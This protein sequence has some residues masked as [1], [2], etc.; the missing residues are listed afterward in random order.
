MN[1]TLEGHNG[2]VICATWNPVYKK[3]TTSDE[4]GLIIVWMLHKGLWWEEMINNRNKSVVK[5]MKWTVDGK[6]ICIIYEDGAVIVGSVDGNRL[7]GKELN[8]EL[9]F[10]EWSPDSKYILFVTSEVEVWVYDADGSKLRLLSLT[11][12]EP[13]LS[14]N[15]YSIAAIHWYSPP[16]STRTGTQNVSSTLL[17]SEIS[18]SL[19]VAFDNGLILLSRGEFDNE[20]IVLDTEL[21]ILS[22]KWNSQGNIFAVTGIL[23]PSRNDSHKVIN[24]I[25]F[26]DSFGKFLR[27]IRIPGENI[28]A[29]TWEGSGL[30]IALAVESFIFFANIRPSYT[31]TYLQNTV[32]YAQLPKFDNNRKDSTVIFWDLTTYEAYTKII[33]NLKFLVSYEDICA[34][35][36]VEKSYSNVDVPNSPPRNTHHNNT[37]INSSYN[38]GY[39]QEVYHVQLRNAIGAVLDSK[40]IPFQP[41][42]CTMGPYLFVATNER[43]VFT[44][45]FSNLTG[46]SSKLNYN[47]ISAVEDNDDNKTS[48]SINIRGMQSRVRLFDIENTSIASAQP[49]ENFRLLTDPINDRITCSAA[50]DKFVLIARKSGSIT[51]YMLPHLNPENSYSLKCEPFRVS[52]NSNSSKLAVIDINGMFSIFDLEAKLVE[53]E[54]SPANVKTLK[55]NSGK[56]NNFEDS[57]EDNDI[58]NNSPSITSPS[59]DSAAITGG[60]GLYYGKK[61]TQIGDRKDVWDMKWAE[62]NPDMICIMEKTKMVV[63]RDDISE[64]PT[65]SSGYIARFKDLEIKA[66]SLDDLTM[67]NINSLSNSSSSN[68]N[69]SSN[70]K[71]ALTPEQ[72]A[73]EC[74]ITFESKLLREMRERVS[75]DGLIQGGLKFADSQI[76]FYPRLWQLL[77]QFALE[78]LDLSTAERA[79]VKIK[80][81]YGIQLVKQLKTMVLNDKMKARAEVA[82]YLN[83]FDEAESIYREIDRK[84]LAIQMRMKIGDYSRVIQLLQTSVGGN[85]DISNPSSSVTSDALVIEAYN[86]IGDYYRDRFQWKKAAE[87]YQ[88]SSNFSRLAETYYHLQAF[89]ELSELRKM[90]PSNFTS[91]SDLSSDRDSLSSY[92]NGKSGSTGIVNSYQMSTIG[93]GDYYNELLL[94]L[95]SYFESVGMVND[96]VDCYLRSGQSKQA[97]DCCVTLNHWETAL[98]LAEQYNYPQVEGLL[99]KFAS[100]LIS[101]GNTVNYCFSQ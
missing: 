10:V 20:Q 30:R 92:T 96:A 72:L 4:N 13:F 53:G 38:L 39:T 71:I 12:I 58:S 76:Y 34:V 65:I 64:E 32:V 59:I 50:S 56:T 2:K 48:P 29:L 80:D 41:R 75:I 81:Y 57:V 68:N 55:N 47:L 83:K 26:Y 44:W 31:W 28:A 90:I 35:V 33:S 63:F 84:D 37:V 88:L 21:E 85:N 17:S 9:K 93:S 1:Q 45:Q 51:R 40:T 77:A 100:E 6:K 74:I 36:W 101:S 69:N 24:L 3:L 54:N 91:D 18:P 86:N 5:D 78:E 49:P 62:D 7:W 94:K 70:N 23:K 25:K 82:V 22:C 61:I 19:L 73:K 89:D 8:L 60:S 95:A 98:T 52:F 16:Y 79:F 97:I 11:S 14:T 27:G 67:S 66:V 99:N 15:D 42:H 87:C 43:T 46:T